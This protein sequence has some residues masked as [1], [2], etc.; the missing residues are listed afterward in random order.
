M[1]TTLFRPPAADDRADLVRRLSPREREVLLLMAEG[2]SNLAISEHLS[3]ELKTV[4]SHVSR[5]FIK[6]GLDEDRYENRRV[7][8]V[9]ML[10]APS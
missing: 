9:L 4:E 7:R 5:V 1:T 10:V 2:A 8:A 3:I 6:L